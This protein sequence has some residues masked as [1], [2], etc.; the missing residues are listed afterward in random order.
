[1]SAGDVVQLLLSHGHS[2]HD[3]LYEYTA[4]EVSLYVEKCIR[5]DMRREADRILAV[6]AGINGAFGANL[7]ALQKQLRGR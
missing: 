1:M 6:Q 4:G 5:E 3:I 2:R 7:D